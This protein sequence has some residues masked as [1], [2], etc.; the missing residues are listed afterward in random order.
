MIRP[1]IQFPGTCAEAMALYET[2]FETSD[3]QVEFLRDALRD[4]DIYREGE[5][6]NR[7]MHA[8]MTLNGTPFNFSDMDQ[9][10]V[11][12]NMCLFNVFFST[13]EA[14]VAAHGKLATG[15]RI[16]VPLGPQFFSPMYGS[17]VDRFG[18]KWQLICA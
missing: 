17:V 5:A 10:A 13:P 18:I 3:K 6:G 4:E 14:V 9:P 12:G 1:T 11:A 2:V 8:G 7:V 15:G 16:D